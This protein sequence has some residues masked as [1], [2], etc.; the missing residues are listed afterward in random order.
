MVGEMDSGEVDYLEH[1]QRFEKF[2]GGQKIDENRERLQ[3]TKIYFHF[4]FQKKKN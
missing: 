1:Q 4:L 3:V 2:H